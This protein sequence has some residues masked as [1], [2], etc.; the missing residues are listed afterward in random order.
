MLF[1]YCEPTGMSLD[2]IPIINTL[3]VEKENIDMVILS[4]RKARGHFSFGSVAEKVV[5]NS[6]VPVVTIPPSGDPEMAE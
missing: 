3:L 6:P 5:K 2:T 1:P 4:T